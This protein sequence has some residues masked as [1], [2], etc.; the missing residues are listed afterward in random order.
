MMKASTLVLLLL[1]VTL[2]SSVRFSFG[3]PKIF[4]KIPANGKSPLQSRSVSS[5]QDKHAVE[6]PTDLPCVDEQ[7]RYHCFYDI[8]MADACETKVE[9]MWKNCRY[10]CS[11]C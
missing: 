10:S 9:E 3:Y 11:Y 7:D 1:V 6:Q 8:V 4:K 2:L 5:D